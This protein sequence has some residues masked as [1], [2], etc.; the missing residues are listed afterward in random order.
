M[1]VPCHSFHKDSVS[2]CVI[3]DQIH[4]LHLQFFWNMQWNGLTVM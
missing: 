1:S 2:M 3:A 4:F